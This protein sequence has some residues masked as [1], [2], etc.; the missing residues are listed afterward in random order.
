M[1]KV[2]LRVKLI[3]IM[4]VITLKWTSSTIGDCITLFDNAGYV[5]T[6]KINKELETRSM[7]KDFE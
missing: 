4:A 6:C 3:L 5:D 7:T 1:R 2:D